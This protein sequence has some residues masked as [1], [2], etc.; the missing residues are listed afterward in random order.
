MI[1]MSRRSIVCVQYAY[2]MSKAACHMAAVTLAADLRQREI[3]VGIVH[4]D[5]VITDMTKISGSNATVTV[6][7][8]AKGILDRV[9]ELTMATSGHFW[10]YQGP[11][12][13]Y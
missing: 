2:R 6:E 9:N 12:L 7:Q 4:P 3:A 5:V 1:K 10:D 13:P 11:T 8:S